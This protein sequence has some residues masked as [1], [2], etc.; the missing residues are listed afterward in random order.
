MALSFNSAG[1][2]RRVNHGSAAGVDNIARG[3]G[4]FTMYA[5]ARRQANGTTQGIIAKDG[6]GLTGPLFFIDNAP[7]EGCLR[8]IVWRA[9]RSDRISSTVAAPLD[10][11]VF[12][13]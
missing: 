11:D 3:A 9:T 1:T 2:N 6:A 12:L 13:A 10:T 4:T 7:S 5:W 8:L